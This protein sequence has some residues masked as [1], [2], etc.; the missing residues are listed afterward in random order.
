MDCGLRFLITPTKEKRPALHRALSSQKKNDL[1]N[2][3]G[4]ELKQQ[5]Q[6]TL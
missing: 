2:P 5:G 4:V 6:T 3:F 1:S